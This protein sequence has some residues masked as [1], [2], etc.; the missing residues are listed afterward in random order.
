MSDSQDSDA[1]TSKRARRYADFLKKPEIHQQWTNFNIDENR[2]LAKNK[3]D[4][5]ASETKGSSSG[6]DTRRSKAS[7]R[8][9]KDSRS[10]STSSSTNSGSSSD[11]KADSKSA[12]EPPTKPVDKL[13]TKPGKAGKETKRTQSPSPAR[14][15]SP[16]SKIIRIPVPVDQERPSPHSR[17]QQ[18]MVKEASKSKSRSR[19]RSKPVSSRSGSSGSRPKGQREVSPSDSDS[20]TDSRPRLK[21]KSRRD[22]RKRKPV[23]DSYNG[24]MGLSTKSKGKSDPKNPKHKNRK[25]DKNDNGNNNKDNNGRHDRR[26]SQRHD[27]HAQGGFHNDG[28]TIPRSFR[29]PVYQMK[30]RSETVKEVS[31]IISARHLR[32]PIFDATKL[33]RTHDIRLCSHYQFGRCETYNV[34]THVEPGGTFAHACATCFRISSIL[35]PHNLLSCPFSDVVDKHT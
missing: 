29:L 30:T 7:K 24:T 18:R 2:K 12:Y 15:V 25:N 9:R 6:S 19:S 27:E 31:R 17:L 26:P 35:I 1:G 8:Q 21:P 22:G 10:S 14:A 4:R 23:D 5:K 32:L 16:A 28:F 33:R 11:S 20:N 3:R 13:E 34:L